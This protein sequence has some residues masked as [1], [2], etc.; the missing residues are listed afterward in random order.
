MWRWWTSGIVILGCIRHL[1]FK[2]S[3]LYLVSDVHVYLLPCRPL[4]RL[5][6]VPLKILSHNDLIGRVIGTYVCRCECSVVRGDGVDLRAFMCVCV[7][8]VGTYTSAHIHVYMFERTNMHSLVGVCRLAGLYTH[9]HNMH[10]THTFLYR[11]SG[12][13]SSANFNEKWLPKG[14]CTAFAPIRFVCIH[15]DHTTMYV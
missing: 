5:P 12:N 15:I 10:Y 4:D 3:P 14:L 8:I 9:M 7:F 13:Y 2:P 11:T 6:S 1:S